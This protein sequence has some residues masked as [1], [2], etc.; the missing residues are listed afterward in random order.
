MPGMGMGGLTY[1]SSQTGVGG[2]N[3]STSTMIPAVAPPLDL[4]GVD[5]DATDGA[6]KLQMFAE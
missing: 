2:F 6:A 5:L 3:R 4:S 1:T